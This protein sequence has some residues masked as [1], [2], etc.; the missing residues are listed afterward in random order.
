MLGLIGIGINFVTLIVAVSA[1][2]PSANIFWNVLA[3]VGA[4]AGGTCT[5][6]QIQETDSC[7]YRILLYINVALSGFLI[8]GLPLSCLVS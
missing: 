2:L 8:I 5:Y 1:G 7:L 6:S 3:V 4:I